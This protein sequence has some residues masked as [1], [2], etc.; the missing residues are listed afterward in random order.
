MEEPP[1][2]PRMAG[3]SVTHSRESWDEQQV[4]GGRDRLYLGEALVPL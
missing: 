2:V 1:G 4:W 3:G